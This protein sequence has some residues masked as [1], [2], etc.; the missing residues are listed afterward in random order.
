MTPSLSPR[1]MC[2]FVKQKFIMNMEVLKIE[3]CFSFAFHDPSQLSDLSSVHFLRRL[4]FSGRGVRLLCCGWNN[5]RVSLAQDVPSPGRGGCH[6]LPAFGLSCVGGSGRAASL[7]QWY[8][9]IFPWRRLRMLH[10]RAESC[11][12]EAQLHQTTKGWSVPKWGQRVAISRS[13]SSSC[14]NL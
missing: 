7:R 12:K 14:L 3:L 11:N 6:S 10:I 5:V 13:G 4:G 2:P 1:Q 9:V 8:S